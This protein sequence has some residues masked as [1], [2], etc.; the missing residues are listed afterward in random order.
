MKSI[1]T[2]RKVRA[3]I[4]NEKLKAKKPSDK[5]TIDVDLD[6]EPGDK[7]AEKAFKKYKLKVEPNGATEV[8]FDVTGKKQDIIDYLQSPYYE[9]ED[10][11][12]TEI[13]PELLESVNE[14]ANTYHSDIAKSWQNDNDIT[15]D[16][17]KLI[18]H[19]GQANGH[20]GVRD[21]ILTLEGVIKHAM[22]AQKILK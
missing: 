7:Y 21:L 15:E 22:K 2:F 10:E 1:K 6:Y 5:I 13:Y 19:V 9:Y 4:L 11:D 12:V 17:I 8:S 14:A 20:E 18:D 16:L 3:L